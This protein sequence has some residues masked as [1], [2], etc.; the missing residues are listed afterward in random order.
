[1]E[2]GERSP[3]SSFTLRTHRPGDMGLIVSRHGALY[4]EEYGWNERFEALVARVAAD[5][6]ENY[7]PTLERC[8]LA[9]RD[10]TFLGSIV[11]AQDRESSNTAKLRLLLV[12]PS[13]RGKGLG[14]TLLQQGI[15][16]ARDAGYQ[17]IVLWTQNVLTSARRLY[18]K[19]GFRLMRQDNEEN[20]GAKMTNEH[21]EMSISK[22]GGPKP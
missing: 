20:F 18:Q 11:L 15:D 10:G 17:R 22:H 5:F 9:E 1:M 2:Q 21:W 13:A 7:K 8:W 12:E 19:A 3:R 4:A 16:F 6:L 14:A